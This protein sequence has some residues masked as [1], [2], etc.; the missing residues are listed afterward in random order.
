MEEHMVVIRDPITFT[1]DFDLPK[2]VDGNLS[3]ETELITK[4]NESLA[5]RKI[6]TR[7]NNYCPNVSMETISMNTKKNK[8]NKPPKF[9]LN[10]HKG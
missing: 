4:S 5:E 2:N 7:L 10:L 8:T 9:V 3:H 1:F 6:K